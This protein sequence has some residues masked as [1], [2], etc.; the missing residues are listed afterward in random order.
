MERFAIPGVGA[1]IIRNENGIEEI[2]I[3]ERWKE[4]AASENGLLEIPAGKIRE[5]ENIF[6][7][8]RREVKEET[9]LDI[10]EIQGEDCTLLYESD[11]YKVISFMPYACNQNL[12]GSYPIM[13]FVFICRA[14]GNLLHNS[15][16]SN[17]YRWIPVNTLKDILI[18]NPQKFYPMHVNTLRKYLNV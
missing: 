6:D 13:V 5:F 11:E 7:T 4:N 12:S 17:N 9:G 2:L 10:T 18:S 14:S 1:L 8:L 15:D 16:E 3:Q